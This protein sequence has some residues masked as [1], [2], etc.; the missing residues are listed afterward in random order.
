MTNH[1][2][3][4][5]VAEVFNGKTP[6]KSEQ[7]V[8]GYPVLKIRDVDEVGAYR[9]VF[10]SYVDEKLALKFRSK[11]IVPGDTLIL[12]ETRNADYIVSKLFI[13]GDEVDNAFQNGKMLT[14]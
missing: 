3:L 13:A 5:D 14:L 6:A 11:W 7:R 4:G 1:Y 9:G 8:E 2:R 10:G 12:N